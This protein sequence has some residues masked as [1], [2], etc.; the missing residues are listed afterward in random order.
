MPKPRIGL[1][2]CT[3]IDSKHELLLIHAVQQYQFCVARNCPRLYALLSSLVSIRPLS[4]GVDRIMSNFTLR[5]N[6]N[7]MDLLPNLSVDVPN[8][9]RIWLNLVSRS[10]GTTWDESM[11]PVAVAAL[12]Q[13]SARVSG[14]GVL[15]IKSDIC[16]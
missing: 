1:F 5:L 4:D 6:E 14:G 13:D 8:S 16:R 7:V 3:F 9:G 15:D 12:P 2:L 11:L 10:Y